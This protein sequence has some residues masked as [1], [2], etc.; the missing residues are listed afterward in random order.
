MSV[1]FRQLS[2][3]LVQLL[4]DCAAVVDP[5]L[6]AAHPELEQ[7]MQ[8]HAWGTDDVHVLP[9]AWLAL[10]ADAQVVPPNDGCNVIDEFTVY[11]KLAVEPQAG[12][13][14]DDMW[15][16]TDVVDA[17]LPIV[18]R[19]LRD[20]HLGVQVAQRTQFG[21]ENTRLGET[22]ALTLVIPVRPQWRHRIPDPVA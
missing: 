5:I 18:D 10:D 21:I 3:N 4:R 19:A 14:G 7:E 8:V 1:T 6:Q 13:A 9:A 17:V 16:L 11:L 15:L 12:G 22:N 20:Q 2:E